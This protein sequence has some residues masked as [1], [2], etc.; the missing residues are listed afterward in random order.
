MS[1]T[2]SDKRQQTHPCAAGAFDCG[3]GSD[4]GAV[5]LPD[6]FKVT[7]IFDNADAISQ[8]KLMYLGVSAVHADTFQSNKTCLLFGQISCGRRSEAYISFI[9]VT[10]GALFPFICMTGV[11]KDSVAFW[12]FPELCFPLLNVFSGNG[13]IVFRDRE[14]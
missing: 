14:A 3:K 10:A 8:Q 9:D 5:D 13:V 11:E 1:V 4:C 12:N 7:D 6:F 2:V